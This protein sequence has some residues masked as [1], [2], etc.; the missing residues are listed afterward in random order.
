[1]DYEQSRQIDFIKDALEFY[2]LNQENV[3]KFLEKAHYMR[4]ENNQTEKNDDNETVKILFFD[5]HKSKIFESKIEYLGIYIPN[6]KTFKW[7]WSVPAF[8]KKYTTLSRNLLNYA[9]N[10]EVQYEYSLKSELLNSRI[11]I[12]TSFQMD[13]HIASASY[14]AKKPFIL[15]Y[16][17][18][19]INDENYIRINKDVDD[20][21]KENAI[22][23]YIY[24]LD[25]V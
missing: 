7:S 14:L 21:D 10:L 5:K 13:I 6:T 3:R 25:F 19:I 8:N 17:N 9:F 11:E 15:K 22:V 23:T 16:Y 2:D 1:M 20:I 24:I 4:Y 18:T 12:L